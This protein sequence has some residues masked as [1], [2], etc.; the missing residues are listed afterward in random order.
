MIKHSALLSDIDSFLE[1][2]GMGASY[3]GKRAVGNSELVSRLRCGGRVW[4]ETERK[5]R[6]FMADSGAIHPAS[7]QSKSGG[8]A[9]D[10]EDSA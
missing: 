9:P 10:T 8:L 3:F 4:P 7:P 1:N 2:T 5:I 6:S